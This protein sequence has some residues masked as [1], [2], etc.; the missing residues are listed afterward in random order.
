MPQIDVGFDEIWCPFWSDRQ[1]QRDGAPLG[2][3]GHYR[4]LRRRLEYDDRFRWRG[5]TDG[6]GS[7]R[8][9]EPDDVGC[10]RR[11]DCESDGAGTLAWDANAEPDLA[12]YKSIS[13]QN[14]VSTITRDVAM[15]RPRSAKDVK[16]LAHDPGPALGLDVTRGQ[17]AAGS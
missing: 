10:D 16:P 7:R 13:A 1:F 11:D 9:G 15:L 2:A 8:G 12:G 5:D 6:S 4:P 14:E 3:E 17:G